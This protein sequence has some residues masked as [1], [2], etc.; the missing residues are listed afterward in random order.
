[1]LAV[2]RRSTIKDLKKAY[3]HK[4]GVPPEQQSF[5][6]GGK[7]FEDARTLEYYR[8]VTQK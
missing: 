7:I 4:D 3:E 1:M 2:S 6:F 5:Y 8:D